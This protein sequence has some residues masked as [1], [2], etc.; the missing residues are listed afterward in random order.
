MTTV[1]EAGSAML[2]SAIKLLCQPAGRGKS[3]VLPQPLVHGRRTGEQPGRKGTASRSNAD[4]C[5]PGGKRG[6]PFR[7]AIARITRATTGTVESYALSDAATD[8]VLVLAGD[9]VEFVEE[10]EITETPLDKLLQAVK[11]T[12]GSEVQ[13]FRKQ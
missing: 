5:D 9:R 7:P 2:R 3:S 13:S 10:R 8:N 11:K 12:F 1:D 6:S 4:I